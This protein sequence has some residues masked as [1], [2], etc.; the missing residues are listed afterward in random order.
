MAEKIRTSTASKIQL[1][2]MKLTR[3]LPRSAFLRTALVIGLVIGLSQALALWFFARNAYSPGI[4][5]YAQLTAL[6]ADTA[7]RHNWLNREMV[8]RIGDA[9]GITLKQ[10]V[11]VGKRSLPF[12]SRQV[13]VHFHDAVESLLKEPVDVRYEDSRPPVLWVS[14]PSFNGHW[15]RVPMDFFRDYDRYLLLAWGVT[16]PL[17]AI[18]G[19]LLI[20]SGL[21]RSLRRLRNMARRVARGE[22]VAAIKGSSIAEI[23]A[24]IGA[25]NHMTDALFQAQQDRDLLLAGVSH[26]LRT[27]LTRLRLAVEFMEEEVTRADMIGD[28][29]DMDAILDQFITFV[30]D[31]ADELPQEINFNQLIEETVQK[32]GGNVRLTLAEDLPSLLL[33]PVTMRRLLLNLLANGM[34]YGKPPIDIST[35]VQEREVELR[36]RDHG[37]GIKEEDRERLLQPFVR[38]DAARTASGGSG[39]GLAICQR[40][41]DMHH[42]HLRLANH[43]DGGMVAIVRLPLAWVGRNEGRV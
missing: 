38:G 11:P 27:P 3:L 20:A 4:Q 31:G 28:I 23:D 39:L 9:T 34:Q 1:S 41:V 21:T 8:K 25:F 18:V 7:S 30:R 32:Y 15:L 5:E 33:K 10:S 13:V 35:V 6:Q 26:D 43:P 29:E 12:L 2:S 14:A 16:A 36:V 19:G 37:T 24:V 22:Q 17:L 42:G 40:I